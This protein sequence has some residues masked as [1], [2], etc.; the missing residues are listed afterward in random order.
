MKTINLKSIYRSNIFSALFI[1]LLAAI[2]AACSGRSKSEQR[3]ETGVAEQYAIEQA[4]RLSEENNLD[5]I[6]MEK[7]LIDVRVR[8]TTLRRRGEDR[9]ADR[10]ISTFLHTLDSVNPSLAASLPQ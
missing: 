1:I 5:T 3:E 6:E 4:L 9:L 10:Y 7:I 2:F 8:E